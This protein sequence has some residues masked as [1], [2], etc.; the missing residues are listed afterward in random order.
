MDDEMTADAGSRMALGAISRDRCDWPPTSGSLKP[1]DETSQGRH[2]N[3]QGGVLCAR[4]NVCF[5]SKQK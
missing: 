3:W 2:E 4:L 1:K 5:V